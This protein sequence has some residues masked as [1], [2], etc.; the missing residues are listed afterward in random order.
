MVGS[1]SMSTSPACTLCPS[2]TW[3][4]RTTPVSNGWIVLVRPLGMILPW[5]DAT[6]SI[7]PNAAQAS[8]RQNMAMM[9]T[10]TARPIGE[11]GVSTTSSAAGRNASSSRSRRSRALGN[12]MTLLADFINASLH[13]IEGCVAPAGPDQ[14]VVGAVLDQAAAVDGDDAVAPAHRRQAVRDDEH[15]AALGDLLH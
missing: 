4:A 14:L 11:G 13:A 10:P 15:G 12:G 5:A 9:V 1:S 8:A 7:F 2:R 6:M 3:I